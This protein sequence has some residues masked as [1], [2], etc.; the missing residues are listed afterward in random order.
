M[1]SAKKIVIQ[2]KLDRSDEYQELWPK[3]DCYTK[4]ETDSLIQSQLTSVDWQIGDIRS[5]IK[6]DLSDDWVLCDGS[7]IR[8]LPELAKYVGDNGPFIRKV[9][10][11]TTLIDK[12]IQDRIYYNGL[13]YFVYCTTSYLVGVI[14]GPDLSRPFT[15]VEVGTYTSEPKQLTILVNNGVFCITWYTSGYIHARFSND[16]TNWTYCSC[17]IGSSPYQ[18]QASVLNGNWVFSSTSYIYYSSELIPSSLNE[19]SFYGKNISYFDGKYWTVNT[20]ASAGY[21]VYSSY[22]DLAA[23]SYSS[24]YTCPSSWFDSIYTASREFFARIFKEEDGYYLV[25]SIPNKN[26]FKRVGYSFSKNLESS[27]FSDAVTIASSG[28]SIIIQDRKVKELN[29]QGIILLRTYIIGNQKWDTN[30]LPTINIKDSNLVCVQ[31]SDYNCTF[32]QVDYYNTS[33]QLP[34]ITYDVGYAYIKIK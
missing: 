30:D 5:T 27:P 13:W 12:P 26:N 21:L 9:V 33:C 3:T 2:Q 7:K 10:F 17:S 25:Y 19:A 6:N 20:N 24:S 14:Y 28:T 16:L 18:F 34:N 29:Q 11:A 4:T 8:T 15:N 23:T 22:T 1:M 31:E 32:Y